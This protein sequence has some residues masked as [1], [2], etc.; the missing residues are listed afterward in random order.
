VIEPQEAYYKAVNKTELKGLLQK[1]GT[2]VG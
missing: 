1:L 2:E